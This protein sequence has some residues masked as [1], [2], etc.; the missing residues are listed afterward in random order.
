VVRGCEFDGLAASAVTVTGSRDVLIE[1]NLIQHV[2]LDYSG[3]PGVALLDTQDC[4]VAGNHVREV[5]HCGIVAGPGRGTRILRNL[6]TGTMSV[7]ADGGGVYL[8]GPQGDS[9]TNGAVIRGNVIEDTRTPYNF[10]LYT[11]YGA[12][13]VTVEENVVA[14]A[15]NTAVLQVTPPLENVVYRGNFWDADPIGSDA[16]PDGVT[17]ENNTTLTDEEELRAATAAVRARAGLVVRAGGA[18]TP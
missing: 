6:T 18:V 3:S 5:P 2:G 9:V 1:G 10:G 17:Y 14:R 4:T 16:A 7:L 8:S 11:D 15:D 13:W 12:A